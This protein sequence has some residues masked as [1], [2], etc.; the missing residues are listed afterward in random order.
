MDSSETSMENFITIEV[1]NGFDDEAIKDYFTNNIDD[2]YDAMDLGVNHHDDRAQVDDIQITEI[3]LTSDTIYIEY[4][5]EY[6]AYHGCR[7]AIY[8]DEDQRSIE[9]SRIGNK[10]IFDLF[11]PPPARSTHEE[12]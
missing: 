10:F 9:G 4:S 12:F 6:S 5:I 3:N 7:D 2:L 11:V 1:A 8:V